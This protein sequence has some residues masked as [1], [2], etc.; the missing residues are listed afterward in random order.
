MIGL[1]ATLVSQFSWLLYLFG[2]FL[3]STGIKMRVM[4]DHVPDIANNPLLKLLR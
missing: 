3:I 1:D 2:A 4:A